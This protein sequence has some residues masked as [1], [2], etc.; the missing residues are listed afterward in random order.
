MNQALKIISNIVSGIIIFIAGIFIISVLPIP[1]NIKT[2]VV[3]SGSMEPNIKT[4][5]V[6]VIMPMHSYK[7]GDIVTFGQMSKTSLPTTHRITNTLV[8]NDEQLFS[9]KGDANNSEDMGQIKAKD[10]KGKVLFSIP[11]LGYGVN[12]IKT[13]LGFILLFILP[14]AGL[15]ISEIINIFKQLRNKSEQSKPNNNEK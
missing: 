13:P 10:V 14:L 2:L 6:I 1:G 12:F 15:G 5:S 7:I 11:F 4:G 3:M 8:V 9:T